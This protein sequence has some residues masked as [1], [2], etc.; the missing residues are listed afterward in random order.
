[1]GFFDAHG[2]VDLPH[3]SHDIQ[4]AWIVEHF[5]LDPTDVDA[6]LQV[7]WE[8]MVAAGIAVPLNAREADFEFQYYPA[9]DR[10]E[11][12]GAKLDYQRIAG[13]AERLAAVPADIGL[14]V[15]QG[16][17]AFLEMRGLA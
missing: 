4:V 5:D 9:D 17:L 3:F 6:V 2:E 15:F 16:E 11:M 8:F 12:S 1:M 14:K 13:D 7:E 10:M